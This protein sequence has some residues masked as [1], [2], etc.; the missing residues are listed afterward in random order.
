ME[1][2]TINQDLLIELLKL[3]IENTQGS[4]SQGIKVNGGFIE[5]LAVLLNSKNE[6]FNMDLFMDK[7]RNGSSAYEDEMKET[8]NSILGIC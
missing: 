8:L 6:D 3:G 2:L 5:S 7:I 1:N 4:W